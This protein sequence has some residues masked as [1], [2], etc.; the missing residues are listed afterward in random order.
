MD[1]N[2]VLFGD[3]VVGLAKTEQFTITNTDLIHDLIIT[4]I[5]LCGA[6]GVGA[7]AANIQAALDA[8]IARSGILEG[9]IVID[10]GENGTATENDDPNSQVVITEPEDIANMA[11][12]L[13]A[14][15]SKFAT[16]TEFVVDGGLTAV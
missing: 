4:D 14:D 2:E 12:Y 3:V 5:S 15:V 16:G 7:A 6:P 10:S 13:A 9:P 8:I 11:L 1:P